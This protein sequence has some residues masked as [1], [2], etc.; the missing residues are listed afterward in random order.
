MLLKLQ[1][2]ICQGRTK[3]SSD[4]KMGPVRIRHR[5]TQARTQKPREVAL[6]GKRIGGNSLLLKTRC[7]SLSIRLPFGPM[8]HPQTGASR[9][10][11]LAL[12]WS[13]LMWL[14]M[15]PDRLLAS[16][17]HLQLSGV[18]GEVI[19]QQKKLVVVLEVQEMKVT[20]HFLF[21]STEKPP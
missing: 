2:C 3:L 12:Y 1:R 20:L 14:R 8:E 4:Q 15:L 17:S 5:E 10:A 21:M 6:G 16:S 11:T 18:L 9:R 7:F 19:L 13:W